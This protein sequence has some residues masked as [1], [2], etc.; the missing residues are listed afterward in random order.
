M[1]KHLIFLLPL[2]LSIL[3]CRT[4]FPDKTIR[5]TPT[6]V[7]VATSVLEAT[8]FAPTPGFTLTRIY[9]KNGTLQSQLAAEIKKAKALGQTPF[10][11][12]DATWCPPCQAITR[13]L[14]DKN[15]L[16]LN[17]YQGIYLIHADV[18]EWG[19]E[20]VATGFNADSIPVFYA[21]DS[22]GKSTG[23]TVSGGAWNEDIPENMAPVLKKFFHP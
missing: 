17:A 1:K 6:P 3:A 2:L 4:L 5:S 7:S 16:M 23:A 8:A 21:V 13:S 22:T 20:T 15:T 18:D 12:F 9:P 11:E 14:A 10:V 19:Q